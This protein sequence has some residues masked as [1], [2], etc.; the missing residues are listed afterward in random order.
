M[1]QSKEKMSDRSLVVGGE[2]GVIYCSRQPV[3]SCLIQAEPR[4]G[5]E[6]GSHLLAKSDVTQMDTVST[7]GYPPS[8]ETTKYSLL[9]K[10]SR[11]RAA[12]ISFEEVL[13]ASRVRLCPFASF[14][15]IM[16]MDSMAPDNG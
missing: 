15:L 11:K 7:P 4:L 14:L 5:G 9:A 10:F 16:F 1:W 13:Q 3:S 6:V 12:H 2:I 8:L